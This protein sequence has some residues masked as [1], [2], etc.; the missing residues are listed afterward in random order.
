MSRHWHRTILIKTRLHPCPFRSVQL[1]PTRYCTLYLCLGET[2]LAS[3][4]YQAPNP[5][6]VV[7]SRWSKFEECHTTGKD[8]GW[9]KITLI[10]KIVKYSPSSWYGQTYTVV[11]IPDKV[12]S[13][14]TRRPIFYIHI[15][16][17]SIYKTL[18]CGP[19]RLCLQWTHWLHLPEA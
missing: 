19:M 18:D 4:W 13:R 9:D 10:W 7:V 11:F 15:D 14:L 16:T 6:E 1:S 17:T 3:Y 12:P 2:I 5:R 8:L